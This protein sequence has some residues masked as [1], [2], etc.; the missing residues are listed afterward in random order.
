MH[1]NPKIALSAP[2]LALGLLAG[3][4]ESRTSYPSLAP[5]AVE[6]LP[7]EEPEAESTAANPVP[8]D[9]ASD[10]RI[11][12]EVAAADAS[13]AR[14][15]RELAPSRRAVAAAG[16]QAAGSEAWI[17]AQQALTR[18]DETRGPVSS[19]LATL[20]AMM[21]ASGGVPSPAL[22]EAWG[23]VSALDDTQRTTFNELAAKLAQP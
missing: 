17:A 7:I 22:A 11:A 12:A 1:L 23:K 6:K 10:G 2:L 21:V 14:F 9:S 3:C 5:R 4:A 20:D 15:E 16:G 8:I 18:L 19:A 13:R